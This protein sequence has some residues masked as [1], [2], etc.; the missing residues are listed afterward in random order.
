VIRSGRR[1]H[2]GAE[3]SGDRLA[4]NRLTRRHRLDAAE[5]LVRTGVL[6]Q[7]TAGTGMDCRPD[8]L[9]VIDCA[10]DEHPG[11]GR[12]P[13]H[14]SYHMDAG[15]LAYLQVNHEHMGPVP[16]G[17]RDRLVRSG[18]LADNCDVTRALEYGTDAVANRGLG[19]GNYHGKRCSDA[20]YDRDVMA[21]PTTRSAS[22]RMKFVRPWPSENVSTCFL[23]HF[24]PPKETYLERARPGCSRLV[25]VCPVVDTR[26]RCENIVYSTG[27][28]K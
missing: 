21:G 16:G 6:D 19:V 28:S 15:G 22:L 2:P 14:L 27:I 24:F 20:A 26:Y 1:R 23:A 3:P 13:Q 9:V 5:D 7:V 18:G 10:E 17:F 25:A 8:G 11:F 4:D 12:D